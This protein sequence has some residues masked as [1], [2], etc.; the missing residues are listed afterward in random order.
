MFKVDIDELKALAST[1]TS[2]G[3]EIDKIDVRTTGDQIGSALPGIAVGASCAKAGEYT[4]G[5]W[6]RIAD[7]MRKL[8]GIVNQCADDVRVTDVEFKNRLDAMDFFRTDGVA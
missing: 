3:E 8:A 4:E 7:R 6:L 1:V 5:A 2:V